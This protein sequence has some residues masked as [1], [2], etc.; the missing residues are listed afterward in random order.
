[1]K[2]GAHYDGWLQK[3]KLHRLYRQN[4]ITNG[5]ADNSK[6]GDVTTPIAEERTPI[7]SPVSPGNILDK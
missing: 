3:L 1:M 6:L 2:S 7:T 4:E 5:G